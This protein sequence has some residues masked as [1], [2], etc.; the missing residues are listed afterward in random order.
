MKTAAGH[1]S[2]HKAAMS[3]AGDVVVLQLVCCTRSYPQIH[4]SGVRFI[5]HESMY[6]YL[7]RSGA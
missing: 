1:E 3:K 2:K 4:A 7:K 5:V 6:M